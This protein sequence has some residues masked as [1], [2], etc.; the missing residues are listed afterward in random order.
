MSVKAAFAAHTRGGWRAVHQDGE[1][2]LAPGKPATFAVWETPA[3]RNGTLP[4]L[5]P[6]HPDEP[7]PD[8]PRCTRT[9]LRGIPIFEMSN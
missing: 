4:D 8:L 3:G 9:V 7:Q 5:L 6:A 2:V 1:G